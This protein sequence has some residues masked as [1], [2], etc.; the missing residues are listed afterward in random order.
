MTSEAA[1]RAKEPWRRLADRRTRRRISDRRDEEVPR[2]SASRG[3]PFT[4]FFRGV[5]S[6]CTNFDMTDDVEEEEE[7]GSRPEG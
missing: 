2:S 5:V 6:D 3:G 1:A 4:P 7:E